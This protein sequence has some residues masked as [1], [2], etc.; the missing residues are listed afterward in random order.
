[1]SLLR[2]FT[3]AIVID[4]TY[5]REVWLCQRAEELHDATTL[6]AEVHDVEALARDLMAVLQQPH[7][8]DSSLDR[9]V[10]QVAAAKQVI[11]AAIEGV[12][13]AEDAREVW[14]HTNPYPEAA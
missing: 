9:T 13:A 6:A 4:P 5:Q 1:M 8:C 2:N 3:G 7:P 12:L 14:R 10:L 11:E